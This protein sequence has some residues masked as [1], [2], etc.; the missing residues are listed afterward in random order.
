MA[1]STPSA[2]SSGNNCQ[3]L[4]QSAQQEILVEVAPPQS[5]GSQ[6]PGDAP[7]ADPRQRGVAVVELAEVH[8]FL[9]SGFEGV[10]SRDCLCVWVSAECREPSLQ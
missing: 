5:I 1:S 6:D 8:A 9:V 10:D 7:A 3:D 2:S 4:F